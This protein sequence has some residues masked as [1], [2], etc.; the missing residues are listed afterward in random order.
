M[1]VTQ[2]DKDAIVG[3]VNG[4]LN[5]QDKSVGSAVL[6]IVDKALNG[7]ASAEGELRS[8]MDGMDQGTMLYSL[9]ERII[10]G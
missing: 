2:Q 6:A 4:S 9:C 5:S 10:E 7:D 8:V 3:T 1:K